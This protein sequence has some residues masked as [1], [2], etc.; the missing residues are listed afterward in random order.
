[1]FPLFHLIQHMKKR[2]ENIV[3]GLALTLGLIFAATGSSSSFGV[4][5]AQTNKT[6]SS[7]S[8]NATSMNGNT[9]G[10]A[11]SKAPMNTFSASGD[12]SSLIFVIQKPINATIDPSSL[13]AATKFVLSGDWNLTVTTGKVTNSAAKFIKVLNDSTRWHTH[14]IINFKAA[15]N[16]IIQL[17]PDKSASVT[18]T[19]DVKLNNTNAWNGVKTN[20][21]ISNGKVF[22]IKLDN[23]ATSNHFQ[24]QPIY[25][26]VESIK[27]ADGNELLKAQQQAMEQK[28]K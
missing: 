20:I 24:G 18:G 23:N 19:V 28:P 14:D 21:L 2:I 1:M 22:T 11:A 3:I 17:S 6:T 15:N 27:D 8:S 26:V 7:A 9:T 5:L 12:I 10:E 16:T 13:S 25:G 4:V